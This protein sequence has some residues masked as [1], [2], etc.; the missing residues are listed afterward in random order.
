MELN[1]LKLRAAKSE[2]GVTPYN[3]WYNSLIESR[4]GE[5]VNLNIPV[6]FLKEL[7]KA[8]PD[9][10][11]DIHDLIKWSSDDQIKSVVELIKY[12]AQFQDLGFRQ[13]AL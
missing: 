2:S 6:S 12:V 13:V 3:K 11:D 5:H 10:A 7:E 4:K 8:F 1:R 9:R